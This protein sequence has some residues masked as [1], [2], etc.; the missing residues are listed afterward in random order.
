MKIYTSVDQLIGKTPL[1]ELCRTQQALGLEARVLVKLEKCNPGG[2]V[3]D[4]VALQMVLDADKMFYRRIYFHKGNLLYCTKFIMHP[5]KQKVKKIYANLFLC[6]II[7]LLTL[8]Y[9]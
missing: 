6:V 9:L 5:G 4:R 7:Y 8:F 3:K 1:L 2:S